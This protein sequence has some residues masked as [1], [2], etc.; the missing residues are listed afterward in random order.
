[1]LASTITSLNGASKIFNFGLI[2]YSNQ[3]KIKIL[4]FNKNLIKK[5]GAVFENDEDYYRKQNKAF[6]DLQFQFFFL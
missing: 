3:A 4:K 5:Y 1:M 6:N 2:T